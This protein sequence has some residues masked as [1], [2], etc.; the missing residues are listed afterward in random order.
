MKFSDLKG[1][2]VYKIVKA[3]IQFII[4]LRSKE[5]NGKRL[6]K[7]EKEEL[8]QNIFEIIEKWKSK[9]DK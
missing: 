5:K 9:N 2:P 8:L 7:K 4:A 1:V 3:V 6:S